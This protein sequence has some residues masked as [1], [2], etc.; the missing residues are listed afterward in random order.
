MV[1]SSPNCNSSDDDDLGLV[2]D[3]KEIEKRM[4][5]T[6]HQLSTNLPRLQTTQLK[7]D[8]YLGF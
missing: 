7:N 8:C 1:I 4:Y 3:T 6:D 2:W 5:K